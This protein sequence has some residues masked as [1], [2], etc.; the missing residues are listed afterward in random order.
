MIIVIL[1]LNVMN[2]I[3]TKLKHNYYTRKTEKTENKFPSQEI[4]TRFLIFST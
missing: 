4:G 2:F 3:P 1:E